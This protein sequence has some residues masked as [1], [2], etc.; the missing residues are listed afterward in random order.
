MKKYRGEIIGHVVVDYKK[1]K[2]CQ[3]HFNDNGKKLMFVLWND[4][5]YKYKHYIND[6]DLVEVVYKEI[7]GENKIVSIEYVD[8]EELKESRLDK[9]EIEKLI[10]EGF[11][12]D[13]EWKK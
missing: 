13:D 4:E 6:D 2:C 8:S 11:F 7:S 9:R 12:K 10:E 1:G 5:Y 3:L